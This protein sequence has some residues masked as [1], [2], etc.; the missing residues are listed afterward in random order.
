MD[1]GPRRAVVVPF[2]QR[3]CQVQQVAG[4]VLKLFNGDIEFNA[5]NDIVILHKGKAQ[6]LPAG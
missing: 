3:H 4:S 5:V 6:V 1:G 2:L